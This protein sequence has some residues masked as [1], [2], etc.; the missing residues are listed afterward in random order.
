M[1]PHRQITTTDLKNY[2]FNPDTYRRRTKC[3]QSGALENVRPRETK[4]TPPAVSAVRS[5]AQRSPQILGIF[6]AGISG[7]EICPRANGGAVEIRTSIM[8]STNPLKFPNIIY[9]PVAEMMRRKN[10]KAETE[11]LPVPCHRLRSPGR[12]SVFGHRTGW[13][14]LN[15]QDALRK[16][17]QRTA[18]KAL[19]RSPAPCAKV[20][21]CM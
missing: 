14:G 11:G 19:R 15:Y 1:N 8:G 4:I 5:F 2:R 13:S 7:R 17:M 6:G 18:Q 20:L 3:R 16:V 10:L 12:R 9:T 21:C